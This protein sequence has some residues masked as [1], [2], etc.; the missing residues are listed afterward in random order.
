MFPGPNNTWEPYSVRQKAVAK[1]A[2]ATN[3]DGGDAMDTDKAEDVQYEEDRASLE[4]AVWPIQNGRIVDWPCFYAFLTHVCN[5]INLNSVIFTP[6]LIIA[7][8]AWSNMDLERITKFLFEQFKVPALSI[9]DASVA[10]LYAYSAR[11][12]CIVDVGKGKADVTAI[13]DFTPHDTG[14][15]RVTANCGGDAMTENLY[16]LLK[17]KG[18]T[19]DM[20]EQL[21]KSPI[22]EILPEGTPIP[23]PGEGAPASAN[24]A[25]AAST[26]A[27]DS[28]AGAGTATGAGDL[29]R[30]PGEGTQVG[31]DKSKDEEEGVLDVASLVTGG[32][33]NEYLARKDKEKAEKATKK[34]GPT[35]QADQAQKQKLPNSRREK[36]TFMFEDHA[37]LSPMKEAQTSEQ[38]TAGPTAEGGMSR[39]EIPITT[40]AQLTR[41]VAEANGTTTTPNTPSKRQGP[42]RREVEVGTERFHVV[43][44]GVIDRIADAVHK[45][46][47]AVP[48][49]NRRSEIWDCIILVGNGSRVRGFRDALMSALMTR[50]HVAPSTGTIFTSELPSNLSTPAGTGANTPQPQLGPHGGGLGGSS[51][52]PMLVAATTAQNP[53]LNP[54]VP[55]GMHQPHL[56]NPH[57]QVPTS[58]KYGKMPEYFPE[59]KE[60]G[61]DEAHFLG[62]QVAAKVVFI[63]DAN[64]NKSYMTRSDF[65]DLGPQGIRDYAL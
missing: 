45:A 38:Q 6:V 57:H 2:E 24:P 23:A 35:N 56:H 34:K 52:N 47:M 33:M 12:A 42:I 40:A 62:A 20:C 39:H 44:D 48:D 5:S 14:L 46:V 30:G 36:A 29:P 54:M 65:N 8:P 43:S 15:T 64:P 37:L 41:P 4:G 3:G 22:C 59:W 11:D 51:A 7:Q 13:A 16:R 1:P 27:G 21:K 17:S 31:E 28:G 53:H 9:I 60:V 19:W 63:S 49:I 18:F 61:Y 58:I 26:G 32:K 55:G 10:S 25:A 50:S